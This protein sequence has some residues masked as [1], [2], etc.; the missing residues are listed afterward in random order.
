MMRKL[1][2]VLP[3][4]MP[5]LPVAAQQ[6]FALPA[7]CEA[8]VTV[9]SAACTVSHHFTCEG[10]PEGHQRRVDLDEGG[11]TYIGSIDAETQWIASFHT[12]TGHSEELEPA[13]V[14]RASLSELIETGV[15]TYDFMTLSDHI[16]PTR[17]V[18]EDRLTGETVVIDGV[19]LDQ[20][21]YEIRSMSADGTEIWRAAGNEYIS[22]DWRM[23]LAGAGT[24]T[25]PDG[26][27][28]SDDSPVEFIF[29]GE[30]GF[31]SANPKHACG[32]VMSSYASGG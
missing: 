9:Q 24:I 18:G 10:D 17:Y 13:P 25:T 5:A 23:F 3:F 29:A 12:I 19:T 20:T 7:G 26:S 16:G 1:L 2:I 27:F 28:E 4:V 14:D 30:P 8:Y 31:L 32:V 6:T 21:S 11:M 22:R 15:N